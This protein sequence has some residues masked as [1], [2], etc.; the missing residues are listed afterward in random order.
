MPKD[1]LQRKEQ[2][3][4]VRGEE[5]VSIM[6]WAEEKSAKETKGKASEESL[7]KAKEVEGVE[8]LERNGLHGK[9]SQGSMRTRT[10]DH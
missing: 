6:E 4:K 1:H 5:N 2:E 3:T 9:C 7:S 10:M 8:G